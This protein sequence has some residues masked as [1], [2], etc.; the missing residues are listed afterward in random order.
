MEMVK[1]QQNGGTKCREKDKV[2]EGGV[3]CSQRVYRERERRVWIQQ[4]AYVSELR[5]LTSVR[6]K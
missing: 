5:F 1:K 4:N 3:V 6:S 2:W